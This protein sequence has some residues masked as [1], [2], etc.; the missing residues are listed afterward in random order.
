MIIYAV[1]VVGLLLLNSKFRSIDYIL[2]F[3]AIYVA[4][5]INFDWFAGLPMRL[6]TSGEIVKYKET[7]LVRFFMWFI[8]TLIGVVGIYFLVRDL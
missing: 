3:G 4:I 5:K 1:L 2:S 7:M 6:G 8:G